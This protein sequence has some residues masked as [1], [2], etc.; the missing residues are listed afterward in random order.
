[1]LT[2]RYTLDHIDQLVA[3]LDQT[4]IHKTALK[5]L[6]NYS[7]DHR[8]QT[9]ATHTLTLKKLQADLLSLDDLPETLVYEYN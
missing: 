3:Q 7:T 6:A 4:A 2:C 9:H 8:I 1:M 5:L